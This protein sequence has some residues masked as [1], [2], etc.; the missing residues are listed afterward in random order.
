MN[1]GAEGKTYPRATVAVG[2]D[3]IQD[4]AEVVG[5]T[6]PGVPPT[7]I[8]VAEFAVFGDIINDPELD[9]DFARVVHG[10]QEYVWHRPLE[11]G[12]TLVAT[13]RIAAIRERAGHGFVTIEVTL[14]SQDGAPVATARATMIERA[15][16]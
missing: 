14:T 11:V 5:Q 13:P 3:R 9:L 7:F 6:V 8:T 1:A 15:A 12:E 2:A 16:P 10:D 4:F